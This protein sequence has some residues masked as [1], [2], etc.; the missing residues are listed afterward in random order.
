MRQ[1]QSGFSDHLAQGATTLCWCWK[2]TR[3]D[4][5]QMG[6][7]DHDRP[8]FF[9]GVAFE[10]A[11]GF[12][13]TEIE[14]SLGLAVDNMDVEGALSSDAIAEADIAAGLYDDAEIILFRVNWQDVASREI[15]S[16][17]N[18]G[19]VTRGEVTFQAEFRGLAHRLNQT[20][21]RTFQFGCDA[22]LGDARCGVDLDT[23]ANKGAGAVLAVTERVFQ[24]SGLDG[25]A[26]DHFSRGLLTWET[27]ANAGQTIKVKTHRASDS[28]VELTL[29]RAPVEPIQPGDTFTVRAGCPHTFEACKAKFANADNF[30]GFPHMPGNDFVLSYAKQDEQEND[31]S[32][33]VG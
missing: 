33:A 24:A 15:I 6:F 7:T 23:A 1:F 5:V 22:V 14:S 27:G 20:I 9:G 21:G 11:T 2:V 17:G 13:G 18:I 19:E 16:R 12:S 29:W 28:L 8:L 30:R 25:F 4:G 3:Q 26:H 10:A 32:A 31:G